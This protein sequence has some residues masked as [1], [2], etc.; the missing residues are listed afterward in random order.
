MLKLG[1]WTN[2]EIG[3][4]MVV[5]IL[6]TYETFTPYMTLQGFHGGSN[7]PKRGEILI[8][9]NEIGIKS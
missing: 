6:E 3:K 5:S 7:V 2:F 4:S 1:T 8:I 9:L